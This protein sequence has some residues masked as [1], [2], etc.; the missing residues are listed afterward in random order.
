MLLTC[1]RAEGCE[2]PHML[3]DNDTVLFTIGRTGSPTSKIGALSLT[4]GQV[5][6]VV[7]QGAR[8]RYVPTGHLLYAVTNGHMA[9]PFNVRTVSTTGPAVPVLDNIATD[10]VAIA[11]N[12]M[13]IYASTG[14]LRGGRNSLVWVDRKGNV[15]PTPHESGLYSYPRISPDGSRI[16]VGVEQDV[17]VLDVSRPARTPLTS[18]DRVHNQVSLSPVP[19]WT[20]DGKRVTFASRQALNDSSIEWINADG[21]GQRERLVR[22]EFPILQ[23]GSWSAGGVLAF[24]Q[25]PPSSATSQ[26]RDLEI[27]D[28]KGQPKV[29][30]FLETRFR[31]RAPVFSPDGSW[32]AF[33]SDV[34]GRDEVYLRPYPGPGAQIPASTNGGVEPVWS[35][36]GGELFYRSGDRMMSVS[37]KMSPGISLGEARV[38]FA[39]TFASD[40]ST[41]AAVPNYDVGP[42]GRFLM[43]ASQAPSETTTALS[44]VLNWFEELQQRAPAR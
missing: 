34:S 6:V 14:Q 40:V 5:R 12:G 18:G 16:A 21:S 30:S 15:T 25:M 13:M 27:F 22:G 8:A 42:D 2:F 43:I 9:V 44:V 41:T 37:V 23:P 33:A 11:Q 39:G 17:W 29:R 20:R 35:R 38:L 26:D 1:G 24:Y 31:E 4:T 36:D 28:P 3:P 32:I 19:A 10:A 7:E